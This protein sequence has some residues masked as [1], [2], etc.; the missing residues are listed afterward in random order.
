[1]F[2][3]FKDEE[4]KRLESVLK[5][6]NFDETAANIISS[7]MYKLRENYKDYKKIVVLVPDKT[8]YILNEI[9]VL[10]KYVN[11]IFFLNSPNELESYEKEKALIRFFKNEKSF[12]LALGKA[13]YLNVDIKDSI[14]K[15]FINELN[16]IFTLGS[17][18]LRLEIFNNFNSFA[19]HNNLKQDNLEYLIMYVMLWLL[20]PKYIYSKINSEYIVLEELFNRFKEIYGLDAFLKIYISFTKILMLYKKIITYNYKLWNDKSNSNQ[21]KDEDLNENLT[22]ILELVRNESKILEQIPKDITKRQ[23]RINEIYKK[24]NDLEFVLND[25]KV[26][27]KVFKS[28]KEKSK[29]NIS[30]KKYKEKLIKNRNELE[31]ESRINRTYNEY[32][33][34]YRLNELKILEDNLVEVIN[35]NIIDYIIDYEEKY[36][37]QKNE[38]KKDIKLTNQI[39]GLDEEKNI[40]IEKTAPHIFIDENIKRKILKSATLDFLETALYIKKGFIESLNEYHYMFF[41]MQIERYLMQFKLD[42]D[43][44]GRYES[45]KDTKC[46]NLIEVFTHIILEKMQSINKITRITMND[47]LNQA[48][49]FEVLKTQIIDLEDI[50]VEVN[51]ILGKITANFYDK[52]IWQAETGITLQN[53]IPLL[54]KEG[55]KYKLFK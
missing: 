40:K 6:K 37:K 26:L 8:E 24:I 54:V 52:D 30:K 34:D 27:D 47:E 19:W 31:T 9:D 23:N 2:R 36:L 22:Y 18:E 33:V 32:E 55:V 42:I 49:I 3:F 43:E 21:I 12:H 5:N 48:I 50:K 4:A 45:L 11:N 7:W 13:H 29:E 15:E 14:L 1:M 39:L 16:N 35:T 44:N 46:F 20:G 28:Y 38:E 25:E 10:N 51:K 17:K 41:E 53:D